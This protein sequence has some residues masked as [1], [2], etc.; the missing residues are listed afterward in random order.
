MKHIFELCIE[1]YGIIHMTRF[2]DKRPIG[3]H[4]R[5]FRRLNSV[6]NYESASARRVLLKTCIHQWGVGHYM[7][8]AN[9]I[10]IICRCAWDRKD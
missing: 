10:P 8:L 1:M 9:A 4:G 2:P 6:L 3:C 7:C 5:T